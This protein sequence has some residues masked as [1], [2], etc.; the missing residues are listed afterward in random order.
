MKHGL[1]MI[2]STLAAAALLL[3]T[4]LAFVSE[5]AHATP[6][7]KF[8]V[9]GASDNVAVRWEVRS[10]PGFLVDEG[11]FGG[12]QS[13]G[14]EFL[15][16]SEFAS[17]FAASIDSSPALTAFK[18][19]E[20]FSRC[21]VVVWADGAF[22]LLVGSSIADMCNVT[23]AGIAGCTF[24]P[25]I[26]VASVGGIAETPNLQ[27]LPV[28]ESS[29]SRGNRLSLVASLSLASVLAGLAFSRFVLRRRRP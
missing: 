23:T 20:T 29:T 3:I 15:D 12:F 9:Y 16:A 22:H 24:N 4:T 6:P 21:F 10:V 25:T 18:T 17:R 11:S 7:Q 1:L 26:T 13:N 27:T 19:A 5:T 2:A 28:A 14:Q 8:C